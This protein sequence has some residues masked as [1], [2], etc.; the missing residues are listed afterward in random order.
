MWPA[1]LRAIGVYLKVRLRTGSGIDTYRDGATFESVQW[2][3]EPI[4]LSIPDVT[5]PSCVSPTR[6]FRTWQ[7]ERAFL[8]QE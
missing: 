5:M 3:F 1:V 6:L 7:V 4:Y 8:H 2:S